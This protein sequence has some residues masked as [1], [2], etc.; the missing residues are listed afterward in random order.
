MVAA[1]ARLLIPAVQPIMDALIV[2]AGFRISA[3]LYIRILQATYE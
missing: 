2:H 1:K 3:A